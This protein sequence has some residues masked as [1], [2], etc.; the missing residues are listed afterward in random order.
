[1]SNVVTLLS[2]EENEVSKCRQKIP[3]K[4][5]PIMSR[6]NNQIWNEDPSN[7]CGLYSFE[8]FTFFTFFALHF[9][10]RCFFVCRCG[11][12]SSHN[13]LVNTIIVNILIST[14]R[15]QTFANKKC[16]H[17]NILMIMFSK[18]S[19]SQYFMLNRS[20]FT[21]CHFSLKS[22]MFYL[23]VCLSVECTYVKLC[24]YETSFD[25]KSFYF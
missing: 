18:Q 4:S 14:H 17:P 7:K 25:H 20:I 16:F 8:V 24:R 11:S 15:N 3:R 22:C 12:V 21:N 5:V 13:S 10:P 2:P 6:Y 19:T 9:R 1:M 23:L